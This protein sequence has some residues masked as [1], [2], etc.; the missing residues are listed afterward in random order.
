MRYRTNVDTFGL[1]KPR[2]TV[3][4]YKSLGGGQPVRE[5]LLSLAVFDR[6]AIGTD[7]KL[8]QFAWPIGMPFVRSLGHELFEVRT[9]L[10][11]RAARVIFYLD[12]AKMVLLHGF[13]KKQQKTAKEDL[14]IAVAR[15]RQYRQGSAR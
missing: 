8:V 3:Y 6:R 9:S 15:L 12:G 2:L 4:F 13:I 1:S 11:D 10:Q 7:I 5:W 14:R